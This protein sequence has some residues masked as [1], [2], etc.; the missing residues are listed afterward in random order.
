[1]WSLHILFTEFIKNSWSYWLY[2]WLNSI[3]W[4]VMLVIV[5]LVSLLCSLP[6]RSCVHHG[7]TNACVYRIYC[8]YENGT[9]FLVQYNVS[10]CH[11]KSGD[12]RLI[13]YQL[14]ETKLWLCGGRL[15]TY[16]TIPRNQ[17]PWV[18][19]DL[20][21]LPIILPLPPGSWSRWAAFGGI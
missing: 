11:D 1:M 4:C 9:M 17:E 6:D 3:Y 19:K 13:V 10:C 20:I 7:T 2:F 16:P 18:T 15:S 8:K 14:L 5:M 21:L 12:R